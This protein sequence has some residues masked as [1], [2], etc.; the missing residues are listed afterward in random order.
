MRIIAAGI[1]PGARQSE[2]RPPGLI[3]FGL[4]GRTATDS[5]GSVPRPDPPQAFGA[6]AGSR[7]RVE[8]PREMPG[9][10]SGQRPTAVGSAFL[11]ASSRREEPVCRRPSRRRPDR[12]D[13]GNVSSGM[14]DGIRADRHF[15]TNGIPHAVLAPTAL[16]AYT[17][18]NGT[19]T[20][21][22]SALEDHQPSRVVAARTGHRPVARL[23]RPQGASAARGRGGA[24]EI[25][26]LRA[27]RL[28]VRRRAG[29]GPAGQPALEAD[30]GQTHAGAKA[31]GAG[32]VETR[33]GR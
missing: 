8:R 14:T 30:M 26:R 4:N 6:L 23:D 32:L 12:G 20:Q 13:A 31:L 7:N 19:G 10:V 2:P 3:V 16:A 11:R 9:R 5:M 17:R 27:L 1:P 15:M 22:E 21:A 28:G 33:G 24:P 18:E 29:E 25:R